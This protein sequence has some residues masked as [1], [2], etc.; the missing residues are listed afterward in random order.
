MIVVERLSRKFGSVVAVD[1]VSFTAKPGEITGL[2]GPNGAGKTTTL[3]MIAGLLKPDSG[4]VLLRGI[5]VAA[6]PREAKALLGVVPQEIALYEEISARENLEFWGALYGLSGRELG[7]R[8]EEVLVKVDLAGRKDPVSKFSGGM[9][10]RLNLAAGLLHRPP[11]LLLDEPTVGIDVHARARILEIVREQAQAGATVLYTTHYLEE[12]EM[13]CD[14]VAIIDHGRILADDDIPRLKRSLGEGRI[15]SVRGDFDEPAFRARVSIDG[16]V[17]FPEKGRAILGTG[18][19]SV[20]QVLEKI[21]ASGLAIDDV[22]VQE[23]RLE[24]VFLKL[25]GRELRD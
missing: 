14:R 17:H 2:L 22:V 1:D 6:S 10:R 12:A 21:L 18:D 19:R 4:R 24:N 15:V 7:S 3:S 8:I 23:P 13:L 20:S 11:V 25:T 5:D 16:T 9:K